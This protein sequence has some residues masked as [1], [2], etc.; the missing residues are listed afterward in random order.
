MVGLVSLGVVALVCDSFCYSMEAEQMDI[1]PH[2]TQAA[3]PSKHI[4]K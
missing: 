1:P 4:F 2:V 3:S